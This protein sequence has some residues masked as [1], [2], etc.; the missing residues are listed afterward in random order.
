M[1]EVLHHLGCMK[2]YKLWDKLPINW[3]AGFQGPINSSTS[4]VDFET[5]ILLDNSRVKRL[6][7]NFLKANFLFASKRNPHL[8]VWHFTTVAAISWS[9]GMSRISL[10]LW[11][12]SVLEPLESSKSHDFFAQY[13]GSVQLNRMVINFQCRHIRISCWLM[14]RDYQGCAAFHKGFCH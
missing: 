10:P 6:K 4:F 9:P 13:F 5:Q 14:S 7:M 12:A 2:P 8:A 11:G 3:L 1:A